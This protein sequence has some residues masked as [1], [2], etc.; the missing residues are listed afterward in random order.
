MG[1]D[2]GTIAATG[3]LGQGDLHVATDVATP[4]GDAAHTDDPCSPMSHSTFLANHQSPQFQTRSASTIAINSQV[5]VE[6][7]IAQADAVVARMSTD[8]WAQNCDKA[9]YDTDFNR[10]TSELNAKGCNAA[11][12]SSVVRIDT[13]KFGHAVVGWQFTSTTRCSD[14]TE[15][16]RYADSLITSVGPVVVGLFTISNDNPPP[17][18]VLG[19]IVPMVKR[20]HTVVHP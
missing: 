2:P 16:L 12:S 1:D 10:L 9:H 6:P 18:F 11:T 19:A 15:F 8:A 14:G 7:T 17:D 3:S 4:A 20:L 13:A 5:T